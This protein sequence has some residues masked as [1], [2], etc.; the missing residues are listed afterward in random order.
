[1]AL[2]IKQVEHISGLAR[3]GLNQ[4]EKE[5]FTKELGE[6]LDYFEKLKNLEISGIQPASQIIELKNIYR[7]DEIKECGHDIQK[8]ILDN[9]PDRSANYFKTAKIL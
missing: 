4:A 1:M 2:S 3:L 7:F 6:I 8:K 9:A 5:K